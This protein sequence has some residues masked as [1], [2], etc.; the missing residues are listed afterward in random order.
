MPTSSTI[1]V[2]R[3]RPLGWLAASVCAPAVAGTVNVGIVDDQGHA[4]ERVV[5][6]LLPSGSIAPAS[7]A[8]PP[9]TTAAMDQQANAFVPHILVV[10]KGTSVGFPNHDT[11]SHHVY[12]F[13]PAKTFEL[14]LYK[15]N[16]PAPVVFEQAGLIV[17]G[18]NIHD[19]M[20]GYILVV[21]TPYFA[22]TDARGSV[23]LDGLPAGEYTVNVWTPRARPNQLPAAVPVDVAATPATELK[24]EIRGKLMPDHD[25]HSPGL[26]WERY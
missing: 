10:Q 21:D 17:L 12:S 9:V 25:H 5:V 3:L 1:A 11:V 15:G 6:Y 8:P 14:G 2:R 24:L 16:T 26:S 7:V 19:G 18:C 4:L 23:T 13:S 20:L 22:T